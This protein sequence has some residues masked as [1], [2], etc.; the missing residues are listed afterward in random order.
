M[1]LDFLDY[2]TCWMF[3]DTPLC[4]QFNFQDAAGPRFKVL[5]N[6]AKKT[7]LYFVGGHSCVNTFQWDPENAHQWKI[8]GARGVPGPLKNKKN[9]Q[10]T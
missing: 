9:S 3:V 2:L 1:F 6:V 5:L 8:V 10:T 4:F 7:C